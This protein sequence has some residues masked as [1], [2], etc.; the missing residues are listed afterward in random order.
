MLRKNE[1][2]KFTRP[3]GVMKTVYGA[4]EQGER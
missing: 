2:V 1:P 4:V 3:D